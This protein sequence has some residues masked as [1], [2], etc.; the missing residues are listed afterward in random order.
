MNTRTEQPAIVE[1]R[2]TREPCGRAG[3]QYGCKGTRD[4]SGADANGPLITGLRADTGD[5][6]HRLTARL[7]EQV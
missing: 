2:V 3:R 7:R 1:N 4:L 5:I 6:V